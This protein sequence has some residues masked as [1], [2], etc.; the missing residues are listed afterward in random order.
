MLFIEQLRQKFNGC[1]S[2][3]LQQTTYNT[4]LLHMAHIMVM[5]LQIVTFGRDGQE[6]SFWNQKLMR[7][8]IGK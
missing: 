3:L 5:T 4:A 8:C 6:G 7:F 1:R 2:T